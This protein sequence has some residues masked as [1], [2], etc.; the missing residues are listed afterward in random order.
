MVLKSKIFVPAKKDY[1]EHLRKWARFMNPPELIDWCAEISP[2]RSKRLLLTLVKYKK[3]QAK[4]LDLGCGTGLNT[5]SIAKSFPNTTACD[6]DK[7]VQEAAR[8]FLSKFNL[9]TPVIIYNGQK[10]PFKD[11]SF[12]MVV[13]IEVYEHAFNPNQLLR[14]ISRVLKPDGIL[15]ITA[16]NKLWPIEGHYHLPFLSYLPQKLAD[17][18]V[19]LFNKGSGYN[20]I[21]QL[22]TYRQFY[23][24]VS[25][26]FTVDDLT[27]EKVINYQFYETDK[28]RGFLVK[29]LA[30]IFKFID[31]Y[32]LN[33]LKKFLLNFSIGW[34]FICRPR[35]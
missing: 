30:P 7:N 34:I 9:K 29:L 28:E 21:Y 5:V 8:N 22:P 33:G 27:F 20:N 1:L 35:K 10:L 23:D 14:E 24:N 25:K 31:K 16:P 18:Y 2:Y 19:R 4:V 32:Q 13:C 17:I 3:R 6:V 11:N 12:D 26:Y 15:N